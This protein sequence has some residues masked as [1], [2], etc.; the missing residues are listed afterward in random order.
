[1]GKGSFHL[2]S[3][4]LK[5]ES[6]HVKA[7]SYLASVSLRAMA[8]NSFHVA[9]SRRRDAPWNAARICCAEQ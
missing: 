7:S 1:M 4:S 2:A 6:S 5:I 9:S 3:L 8:R